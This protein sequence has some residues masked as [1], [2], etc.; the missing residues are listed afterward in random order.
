MRVK[1]AVAFLRKNICS[2]F[3]LECF[4]YSND[5]RLTVY[6]SGETLQNA[7]PFKHF[8]TY[9]GV[10][11]A[12]GTRKNEDNALTVD[13]EHTNLFR[14]NMFVLE[15]SLAFHDGTKQTS[16]QTTESVRRADVDVTEEEWSK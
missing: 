15:M 5:V 2:A 7:I 14:L 1:A 12:A 11:V 4:I 6:S 16:K 8:R 3:S 9:F 13:A 10:V